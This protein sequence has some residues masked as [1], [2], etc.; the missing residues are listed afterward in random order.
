MR[1][2]GYQRFPF[3]KNTKGL[4]SRI[5]PA[6]SNP[7]SSSDLLNVEFEVF[8]T[9][10]THTIPENIVRFI[11]PNLIDFY[12]AAHFLPF[13]DQLQITAGRPQLPSTAEINLFQLPNVESQ[14]IDFPTNMENNLMFKN[15]D[16]YEIATTKPA[17]TNDNTRTKYIGQDLYE[18]FKG[19]VTDIR[20]G[21]GMLRRLEALGIR[22][23]VTIKKVSAQ[24]MRGP[25]VVRV[26]NTQAAIGFGMARHV[27]VETKNTGAQGTGE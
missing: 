5:T 16:K 6:G 20:G 23:G 27:L 14:E 8:L 22:Q 11:Y 12:Y 7:N 15:S 19:K 1:P 2:T 10:L 4:I 3:V 17:L 24:F 9:T 18:W 21:H 25:L 26:G 13:L